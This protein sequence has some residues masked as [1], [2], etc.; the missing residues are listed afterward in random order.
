MTTPRG[1]VGSST[2]ERP[3]ALRDPIRFLF[4]SNA[5]LGRTKEHMLD[6]TTLRKRSSVSASLKFKLSLM[7]RFDLWR[8]TKSNQ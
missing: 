8:L 4:A 7:V 5:L 1:H 3:V 6:N 2:E